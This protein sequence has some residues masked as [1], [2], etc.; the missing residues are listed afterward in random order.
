MKLESLKNEK[1]AELPSDMLKNTFGGVVMSQCYRNGSPS[2]G[3]QTGYDTS[4]KTGSGQNTTWDNTVWRNM[5]GRTA[6]LISL[7]ML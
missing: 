4:E 1:F 5:D 3:V 6:N 7:Q 2:T